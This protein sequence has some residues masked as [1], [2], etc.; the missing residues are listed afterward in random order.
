LK[1]AFKQHVRI[2]YTPGGWYRP[3]SQQPAAR[4]SSSASMTAKIGAD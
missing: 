3:D 4:R 1:E 2:D